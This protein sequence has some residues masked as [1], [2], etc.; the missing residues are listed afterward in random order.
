MPYGL[1]EPLKQIHEQCF[2]SRGSTSVNDVIVFSSANEE[3]SNLN[4]KVLLFYCSP[5]M[6]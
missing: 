1:L 4:V 3:R 5:G 6:S 2:H